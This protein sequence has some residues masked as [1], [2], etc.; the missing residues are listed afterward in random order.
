MICGEKGVESESGTGTPGSMKI[1][2][3]KKKQTSKK[4]MK[5]DE[6]P[7]FKRTEKK[8]GGEYGG[9]LWGDEAKLAR[10]ELAQLCQRRTGEKKIS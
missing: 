3:K 9:M 2:V 1:G 5:T 7:G 4:R 6:V 10:E 8:K